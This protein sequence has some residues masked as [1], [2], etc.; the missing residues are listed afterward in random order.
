MSFHLFFGPAGVCTTK[1][2]HMN[3]MSAVNLTFALYHLTCI[4]LAAC[5]AIKQ[6]DVNSESIG[7][8][9][10]TAYCMSLDSV[11]AARQ[12]KRKIG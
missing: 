10:D 5:E 11:H 12:P 2:R 7:A 4:K 8:G 1:I 3:S 9:H 6:A